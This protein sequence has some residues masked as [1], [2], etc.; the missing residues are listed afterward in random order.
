VDKLFT[1]KPRACSPSGEA[2]HEKLQPF[3]LGNLD[4]LTIPSLRDLFRF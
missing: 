1:M 3:S 2:M 4:I